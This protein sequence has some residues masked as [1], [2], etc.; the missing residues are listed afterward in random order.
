M[1]RFQH[2]SYLTALVL[3]PVLIALFVAL[4]L[5]RRKKL[6]QIGMV[7]NVKSQLLGYIPARDTLKFILMATALVLVIIGC[8]NLQK[9]GS[10]ET[11]QRKGVDVMIALDLSKSMLAKD[12]QPDR[13]TRAKQLIE[14]LTDKMSN[15]RVGL[16]IFAGRSYLQ[17]PLTID[18]SALKLILQT[19]TPDMIPTQG[20]VIGDAVKLCNASFS[21]KE[22]KFK[23]IVLI[24]DGEDHDETAIAAVKEATEQG[25]VIHTVGI[26]S[27]QG[28][29][30]FDPATNA[31]K[32]DEQGN[33]VITKLNEEELKSIAAAGNGTYTLLGNTDAAAGKIIDAVNSMEQRNLGA[34]VF[35]NYT[36][37]FQYFLF[38][39]LLLLIAEWLLPGA[40]RLQARNTG[41]LAAILLAVLLSGNTGYAQS[42]KA[43][44]ASGN[45]LY[46][47]KKYDAAAKGYMMAIQKDT[48]L[49]NTGAYN[50]G[51]ALY[52][53]KKMDDARK[54]FELAAK[55]SKDTK[56]YANA[57]YNT[58]N[59]YMSE[60]KWEDAITAYKNALRKNPQD[61]D[62]KYNLSY[63]QQMLKKEGGGGKDKNKDKNK[64][65][66]KDQKDQKKNGDQDK[67][68]QQQQ[69]QNQGQNGDKKEEQ[70]QQPQPQ[71]SK[72]SEKQ[73]EQI[74]N[75]L[76]QEEKKLQDKNKKRLG[77]P[78]K[79]E[80]DW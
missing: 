75:A 66:K 28:A 39:G 53:Q 59:T 68:E 11:V 16:V 35:A 4:L 60:R 33:Q 61:A 72:L 32:L 21:S 45:K 34:V 73:A 37:Y 79:M 63:A 77:T 52:Q 42:A 70:E 26:G 69:Q 58:G 41:K 20:T 2:S 23:S 74:L 1:L 40:R 65:D 31:P 62:A 80:K 78:V 10:T 5:W 7:E 25:A 71:P 3:I 9:G 46:E 67:K 44:I 19:V 18:Y 55:K 8:A 47:Q 57:N 43:L 15:D 17:V 6:E 29:P 27:P 49:A 30:L 64:D 36:S 22:R 38:A 50:L 54:A 76:Q 51:N 48:G 12:I 14:R 56:D 13:L 24:S